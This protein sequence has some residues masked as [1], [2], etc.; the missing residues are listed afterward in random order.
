MV[1]S[2][3]VN[4]IKQKQRISHACLGHFLQKFAGHRANIGPSMSANLRFIT[5]PTQRHAN[6][7]PV[8]GAR[9]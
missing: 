3:F 1:G 8:C 4:L 2:H 6:K 5:H 9:Q 7:L